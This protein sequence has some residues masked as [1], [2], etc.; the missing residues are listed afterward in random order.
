MN[1]H[2]KRKM[3]RRVN[4]IRQKK[5]LVKETNIISSN[6]VYPLGP[7]IS[8]ELKKFHK[9]IHKCIRWCWK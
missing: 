5:A 7:A 2:D 4:I 3:K 6:L 9:K 8:G 1:K